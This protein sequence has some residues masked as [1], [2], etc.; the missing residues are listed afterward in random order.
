M[1]LSS[2]PPEK[3]FVISRH[4]KDTPEGVQVSYWLLTEN[5]YAM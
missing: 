3:G 2:S 1:T 5:G 4:W